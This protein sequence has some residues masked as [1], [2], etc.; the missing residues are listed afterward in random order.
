V[1]EHASGLTATPKG[2]LFCSCKC[3]KFIRQNKV[4][5]LSF[6]VKELVALVIMQR[7]IKSV[8]VVARSIPA[9][10]GVTTRAWT[11]SKFAKRKRGR[12]KIRSQL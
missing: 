3:R 4:E 9:C 8:R 7:R 1:H 5:I 11:S 6:Q 2:V 12:F 10:G